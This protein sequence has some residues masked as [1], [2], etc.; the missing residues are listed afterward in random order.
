ML[1]FKDNLTF[2][3]SIFCFLDFSQLFLND[4]CTKGSKK[5]QIN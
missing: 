5:Q 4:Q 3:K 1:F 2:L